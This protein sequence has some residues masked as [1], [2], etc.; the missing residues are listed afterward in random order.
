M[1]QPSIAAFSAFLHRRSG[2]VLNDDKAYLIDNRLAP[3]ASRHGFAS[4]GDLLA[5]LERET[6]TSL[7]QDV[8]DAMTINET[9][10]FRDQRPFEQIRDS[11]LP[12][13][14]R[15]N[16][17]RRR[18]RIWSA[19]CSTGQEPYSLAM[20]LAEM[21]A[22]LRGWSVEILATDLCRRVLDR[23][24]SGIYSQFE[25]QRGMPIGLLT[26]YFEQSGDKWSLKREIRNRVSFQQFNLL[27]DP[28]ALGRFDLVLCR[29]VL[30]YF[31]HPTKQRTLDRMAE[32]LSPQGY[33]IL[34][35][36]EST[37]NVSNRF[38]PAGD[39]R[40][41]YRPEIQPAIQAA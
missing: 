12:Q 6:S 28:A 11:I 20:M 16:A 26:K 10:F 27:D 29:N 31:D 34:G 2:M 40:G 37:M 39:L 3:V 21:A 41:V 22:E 25:V 23:A 4:V 1:T 19:A 9:L 38:S 32:T 35:G 7:I 15:T 8:V 14:M 33:L 30:I 5:S 13:L 17:D 18:I 36:A 24:R